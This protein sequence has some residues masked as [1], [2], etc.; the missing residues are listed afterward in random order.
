MSK[1]LRVFIES[2]AQTKTIQ[3]PIGMKVKDCIHRIAQKTGVEGEDLAIFVPP[4]HRDPVSKW[5]TDNQTFDAIE[6]NGDI[7]YRQKNKLMKVK[8]LDGTAR[9]LMID[10][11][12]TVEKISEYIG[13]T[14]ELEI[15]DE[16]SLQSES[17]VLE[18]KTGVEPWLIVNKT[19]ED[20][21]CG[22]ETVLIFKKKYYFDTNVTTEDPVALHLLF[23]QCTDGI[24]SGLHPMTY[25]EICNIASIHAQYLEG[26]FNP[27]IHHPPFLPLKKIVPP[28]FLKKEFKTLEKDIMKEWGKLVGMTEQNAKYKYVQACRA[29]K[30][31]GITT[32]PC[33]LMEKKSIEKKKKPKKI[34]LGVTREA[35]LFMNPDSK[36]IERSWAISKLR[37]WSAAEGQKSVTLDFGNHERDYFLLLTEEA[38][39]I[40]RLLNGY[41]D[42]IVKKQRSSSKLLESAIDCEVS[43]EDAVLN[44]MALAYCT[45]F[46]LFSNSVN[47]FAPVQAGGPIQSPNCSFLMSHFGNKSS[48]TSPT[49][50]QSAL[51][52]MGMFIEGINTISDSTEKKSQDEWWSQFQSSLPSFKTSMDRLLNLS[53][54]TK[55]QLEE[56]SRI[57]AFHAQITL[58]AAKN[59]ALTG[60][61]VNQKLLKAVKAIA[62]SMKNIFGVNELMAR[63]PQSAEDLND[64]QKLSH[65]AYKASIFHLESAVKGREADQS[66]IDLINECGKDVVSSI[67]SL[68]DRVKAYSDNLHS[69]HQAILNRLGSKLYVSNQLLGSSTNSLSAGTIVNEVKEMLK[70]GIELTKDQ[71]ESLVEAAQSAEG[72]H[73]L[74]AF[75]T[76]SSKRASEALSRLFWA[77]GAS[78]SEGK[79][80]PSHFQSNLELLKQAITDFRSTMGDR[81]CIVSG[82]RAIV[83]VIKTILHDTKDFADSYGS[84]SQFLFAKA[85][86]LQI[87][88]FVNSTKSLMA[89]PEDES[90]HK[91]CNSCLDQI[92]IAAQELID[93]IFKTRSLAQ[94]RAQSKRSIITTSQLIKSSKSVTPL[95]TPQNIHHELGDNM[96]QNQDRISKLLESLVKSVQDVPTDTSQQQ[97]VSCVQEFSDTSLSLVSTSRKVQLSLTEGDRKNQMRHTS[98]QLN[99]LLQKLVEDCKYYG[100]IAG[101]AD[102]EE[103]LEHLESILADVDATQF[104]VETGALRGNG[105][106]SEES[107]NNLMEAVKHLMDTIERLKKGAVQAPKKTPKMGKDVTFAVS[108]AFTAIKAVIETVHDK[109]IQLRITKGSKQLVEETIE[110]VKATLLL[111]TG[112]ESKDFQG[113]CQRMLTTLSSI[114]AISRGFDSKIIDES[115]KVINEFAKNV[116]TQKDSSV[117]FED[118]CGELISNGKAL[119]AA[120]FQI[121]SLSRTDPKGLGNAS[122]TIASIIPSFVDSSNLVCGSCASESLASSL[123]EDSKSLLL[124]MVVL[125]DA[126]KT[127]AANPSPSNQSLLSNALKEA[128]NSLSL[129][130]RSIG[131]KE[132]NLDYREA[133]ES[134]TESIAR[135]D[136]GKLESSDKSLPESIQD[137]IQSIKNLSLSTPAVASSAHSTPY[138][139]G[140]ASKIT[141]EHLNEVVNRTKETLNSNIQ[142]SPEIYSASKII[143]SSCREISTSTEDSTLFIQH[144]RAIGMATSQIVSESKKEAT[145]LDPQQQ[146]KIFSAAQNMAAATSNLA[147]A[148]KAVQTEMPGAAELVSKAIEDLERANSQ[149]LKDSGRKE[150]E[151][152]QIDSKR[153]I[154]NVRNVATSISQLFVSSL[155]VSN[156]PKDEN[157]SFLLNSALKTASDSISQLLKVCTSLQPGSSEYE[158]ALEAL[159]TAA[160]ELGALSISVAV[161]NAE[162]LSKGKNHEASQEEIARLSKALNALISE[163]VNATILDSSELFGK[164]CKNVGRVVDEIV[165][166][167]H[168]TVSSTQDSILQNELLSACKAMISRLVPFLLKTKTGLNAESKD[169][170][171]ETQI[172]SKEVKDSIEFLVAS[173]KMNNVLLRELDE[174]L[175]HLT[176]SL[177]SFN[178]QKLK[179]NKNYQDARDD[180]NDEAKSLLFYVRKLIVIDRDNTVQIA[181]TAKSIGSHILSL[182]TSTLSILANISDANL[183]NSILSS[184]QKLSL[185]SKSVIQIHRNGAQDRS[186]QIEESL[187]EEFKTVTSSLSKLVE[188]VKKGKVVGENENIFDDV[189]LSINEIIDDLEGAAIFAAAGQL[190]S[191]GDCNGTTSDLQKSLLESTKEFTKVSSQVVN[192]K[193]NRDEFGKSSKA[194]VS[195]LSKLSSVVKCLASCLS[196][197]D[198]QQSLLSAVKVIAMNSQQ[199]IEG[200]KEFQRSKGDQA[201]NRA[202]QALTESVK[203]IV[204]VAQNYETEN[205]KGIQGLNT[206]RE[207]L[208]RFL[209]SFDESKGT[210]T[211]AKDLI[212]SARSFALASASLAVSS[213]KGNVETASKNA[214]TISKTLALKCKGA[215]VASSLELNARLTEGAKEL[216]QSVIDSLDSLKKQM[217]LKSS[218]QTSESSVADKLADLINAI[219][220]LPGGELESFQDGNPE[221]TADRELKKT[222]RLI[223]QASATL[224][225]SR[226]KR[227]FGAAYDESADKFSN[228]IF[229]ASV[230]ITTATQKLVQHSSQLQEERIK[231]QEKNPILYKQDPTWAS[232]LIA[233]TKLVASTTQQLVRSTIAL[234]NGT[235]KIED[236]EEV[237]RSLSNATLD[238]VSASKDKEAGGSKSHFDLSEFAKTV[239]SMISTL[240]NATKNWTKNRDE[241]LDRDLVDNGES[242]T[243]KMLEQHIKIIRLEKELARA[244]KSIILK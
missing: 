138:N 131:H 15:A 238:L 135:I 225:A 99:Q 132:Q 29:L 45:D 77:I 78:E 96:D 72:D 198:T 140:R 233:A 103:S 119:S 37:R 222:V 174:T 166:E 243:T 214:I 101:S 235:G 194:L 7:Q 160:G 108:E 144:V 141:S 92:E 165:K 83:G 229:E 4:S 76:E 173:M 74:L 213:K 167:L 30:T 94:V 102:V 39:Q 60:P 199:L 191:T 18:N 230:A 170:G 117:S 215:G 142:I 158:E 44:K 118:R 34:L 54:P 181:N 185:S 234:L 127:N 228:A 157:A 106:K 217:T 35:L 226:P 16:Y 88:S 133:L 104:A 208:H 145:S 164:A 27:E 175:G 93:E 244:R 134:V 42:I 224:L 56:T 197:L 71:I 223:G 32:F 123:S 22:P 124:K 184:V 159:S 61:E 52:R 187:S 95:E 26:R 81:S 239:A 109:S 31:W 156:D 202:N 178:S 219:K 113:I 53:F 188:D 111:S 43:T 120:M 50:I 86:N 8:L 84:A 58:E 47:P 125:L 38:P 107:L 154:N 200:G 179:A 143:K 89:N 114:T 190:E 6:D 231:R 66:S 48:F 209:N 68:L 57:A 5:L 49:H 241:E 11:T 206:A 85:K 149:M 90:N 183:R 70:Q 69:I 110:V 112:Q 192:S 19:L 65:A 33:Q 80:V 17:S 20:Q 153:L 12:M 91:E 180:L 10:I 105:S 126:A 147:K 14:M 87:S 240:L 121:D 100:G 64:A 40:S 13:S 169:I 1:T 236:L 97:F 207:D 136:D 221:E 128:Q 24:I 23:V 212:Q 195:S 162:E 211:N 79:E 242:A 115:V 21:G 41:I 3:F 168:H 98:D 220:C 196:D 51:G 75:L 9:Q 189:I 227:K 28:A 25:A 201:F 55:E 2:M 171:R 139:L 63:N 67:Y 155:E 36:E 177:D 46:S 150:K 163:I 130:L 122:R 216:V 232:G 146:A 203:N 148:S 182:L 129:L 193:A 161:G 237:A 205:A 116:Q 82:A 151:F 172:E 59:A 210:Q 62:D 218:Q 186:L 176:R 137:L 73:K 204:E 152:N